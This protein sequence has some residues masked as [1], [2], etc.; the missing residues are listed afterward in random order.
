M[1]GKAYIPLV[2]GLVIGVF[3]IKLTFDFVRNARGNTVGG[4]R[5]SV[6][7]TRTTI[8]M[9]S[10]ITNDMIEVVQAPKAFVPKEAFNKKEDVVGRVSNVIIPKDMPVVA[11][12]L[13]PKGTTAGMEARIPQGY[14]AVAVKVDESSGV[15]YLV[16]PGSRV[17]VV[18]VM[19]A[20]R[21]RGSETISKTIL[22][23]IE[24]GAVGQELGSNADKGAAVTKSVTLLLK[25]EDVPSLH[26]AAQKGKILLAMRNQVDMSS[27]TTTGTTEKKLLGQ[28]S[29]EPASGKTT[30]KGGLFGKLFGESKVV[31]APPPA[32]PAKPV[33]ATVV[34]VAKPASREWCVELVTGSM[35]DKVALSQTSF[36][37]PEALQRSGPGG[38]GGSR[39]GAASTGGNGGGPATESHESAVSAG[40]AESGP[41]RE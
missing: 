24:V 35:K 8:P 11:N 38:L 33:R 13:A 7:R 15:A 3:A 21:G 10:E 9:A 30:S 27:R 20:E 28:E 4:D 32:K 16:K 41:G 22:Q 6:V 31:A 39:R 26:L 36:D 5:V 12:L 37:G 14:R 19:T 29:D 2:V 23:N 17:D 40:G 1:K 34:A 25:P 18:A